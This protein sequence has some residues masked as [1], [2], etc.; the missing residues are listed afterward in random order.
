MN[1]EKGVKQK[2]QQRWQE[3]ETHARL[4]C[5]QSLK[6]RIDEDPTT[7][8]VNNASALNADHETIRLAV[9][10]DL[11]L[12]SRVRTPKHLLTD[13]MRATR[14]ERRKKVRSYLKSHGK[15]VKIYSNK[16]GLYRGCC[17]Q[18]PK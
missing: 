18:L 1:D 3:Q 15:T 4:P 17:S 5:M 12:K 16:K 11:H 14:L 7:S 2:A 8:M 10:K 6:T 13:G 9:H